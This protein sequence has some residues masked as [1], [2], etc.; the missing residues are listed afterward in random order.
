VPEC[1]KKQE[2][3]AMSPAQGRSR[4]PTIFVAIRQN[5]DPARFRSGCLHCRSFLSNLSIRWFKDAVHHESLPAKQTATRDS[6]H[7]RLPHA[8]RAFQPEHNTDGFDR[9]RGYLPGWLAPSPP[10]T[11]PRETGKMG[12][13]VVSGQSSCRGL[14]RWQKTVPGPLTVLQLLT[15]FV[16]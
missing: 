6:R 10:T 11:R 7:T 16:R 5:P 4:R 9:P 13:S 12:G 15:R 14:A 3:D 2:K 1:D 8:A